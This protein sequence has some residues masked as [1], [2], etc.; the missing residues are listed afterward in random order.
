MSHSVYTTDAIVLH[1]A[2]PGEAD[3]VLW[4]LTQDLGLVIAK[5]QSA[6]KEVSK[7]R[8]HL[9]TLSVLRVSLVRGRYQWRVTGTELHAG[10]LLGSSSSSLCGEAAAA[11]ARVASFVRRMTVVDRSVN[12]YDIVLKAHVEL[13]ATVDSTDIVAV[14]LMAIAKILVELGYLDQ[15]ALPTR[16]D[17]ISSKNKLTADVNKA[18]N[19][20]HL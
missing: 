12:L 7:M 1:R 9:Q 18:L 6:R 10:V 19:E 16:V 15:A 4:L 2:T 14:E 11:F 3:T 5:A 8:S 17:S 13:S 20:S